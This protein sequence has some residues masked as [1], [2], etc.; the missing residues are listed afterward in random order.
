[1]RTITTSECRCYQ[2]CPRK[3]DIQ[4][5]QLVRPSESSEAL[6][7]GTLVHKGLEAW[8]RAPSEP[9]AAAY[10]AMRSGGADPVSLIIAE[11]LMALYDATWGAEPYEVLAVEAEFQ[12]DLRNPET[13]AA[14]RTFRLG[15]KIDAVVRDTNDGRV[16]IV[17]HKTSSDDISPGS[18]YWKR[19]QIDNQV[20]TYFVGARAI[21]Y[22]VQACLYDVIGKPRMRPLKATP[23]SDRRYKKDGSLYANQRAEDESLDDFRIRLREELQSN[24]GRW[25]QRGE[26]VR[27]ESEEQDAAFDLWQVSSQIRE[28]DR[29]GRHP[30]NP[31][32]CSAYGR[33]CEFFDVCTGTT[34]L[35]DPRFRRA[36]DAHEELSATKE[37]YHA[38]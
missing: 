14:S 13:G 16:L 29:T 34:S 22:D 27:L 10:E 26:V 28:A 8:W 35:D 3:H 5:N 11:E 7:F 4:Y 36:S 6:R 31:S 37:Q 32:Q 20:S 15:G 24:P 9:L 2:A 19:L 33:T 12:T 25:L 17:E 18:D 23:E 30:R 21:G 38:S 1:M